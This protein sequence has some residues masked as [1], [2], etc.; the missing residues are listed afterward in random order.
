MLATIALQ[1]IEVSLIVGF[2][3]PTGARKQPVWRRGLIGPLVASILAAC[4][5]A[6]GRDEFGGQ[7]DPRFLGSLGEFLTG[8][9]TPGPSTLGS[10]SR[11]RPVRGYSEFS[12][13]AND[14]VG[15]V[16][17]NDAKLSDDGRTFMLNFVNAD[18]QE[19]IRVV[20]EEVLHENIVVDPALT[21]QVTV[22]TVSPVSKSAALDVVRS[23]LA[24]NGAGLSK[25]DGIYR[26]AATR[27]NGP[28]SESERSA[29]IFQLVNIDA[30]QAQAA[31]QPFGADPSR[32]SALPGGHVL[33]AFAAPADLDR[34]QQ[35]LATLDVDQLRNR[36]FS[37]VPL[38][39]AGAADVA[40]E[41]TTMFASGDSFQAMPVERMNAVLLLGNSA[42]AIQRATSWIDH[43]DQAG[44]DQ[45]SVHIYPVQNRRASDLAKVLQDML[46]GEQQPQAQNSD[47]APALTAVTATTGADPNV[48]PA[49][50]TSPT[51]SPMRGK[52]SPTVAVSANSATNSLVVIADAEVYPVIEQAIRRLDVMPA[53][54]LIE[55]TIAEV[56]LNNNL[57]HGVRWYFETG[58]HGFL[59][60]DKTGTSVSD[61]VPGFNYIFNVPGARV[62][63]DALEDL[64]DV[65]VISSPALTVLD[66][67][68][69]TL[70]VGDQ[71]P[72]ATRSSKSVLDP[73]APVV[74]DIEM[75]DTGIIL[76]VRPRVNAG[77]LVQLDISQEI[78][79]V[80]TTTTSSINS[81]TIRQRSV[82]SSV[83]VKSG[84]EIVL[85]GLISTRTERT[86]S[87]IPILKDIPILGE[88]FTSDAQRKKARTE[89][90]IMIRPVVLTNTLDVQAIT[91]EIRA[92][93]FDAPRQR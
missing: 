10:G 15:S 81:P 48:K 25:S 58:N 6:N 86:K 75:K 19:F 40:R 50:A 8:P 47:I 43:L 28:S 90:L 21:G 84:T 3:N 62:V 52:T 31:L 11:D 46:G 57:K 4:S 55:A 73:S 27:R 34:Y 93:I 83:V 14:V 71:V 39:D 44:Q 7:N 91:Q 68:V 2:E 1:R 67:Q 51:P 13:D 37:L 16:S 76:S 32:V 30:S 18:M 87:G 49:V 17:R 20:F 70:K 36:S 64:T 42:S 74:N 35:V 60:A 23:V 82:T 85:G 38:H 33:V 66:N 63:I 88:A 92:R 77:G 79:D 5:T 56:T 80:V 78:S 72:I 45:R 69:A 89:F 59:L 9:Q 12:S 61:V 54:V 53:Q 41:L 65:D 24:S 26:I 29:R 22:R